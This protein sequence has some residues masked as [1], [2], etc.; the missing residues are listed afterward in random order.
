MSILSKQADPANAISVG[1]PA[2]DF[3][4]QNERGEAWQLSEKR[5]EVVALLFYSADETLVCTKQ[6]CA[7][8]DDWASYTATGALVVGISQGTPQA[9][10]QFAAH[11]ALPLQLLADT[12]GLVTRQYTSG[13]WMPWWATRALVVVDAKGIIRYRK[14]MLRVF[15]PHNDEVLAAIRMAQYDKIINRNT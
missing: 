4:L 6:L 11:H 12:D 5:G 10:Q 3:V 1:S 9:H 8:R 15:R 14:I 7:V 2:P 13:G